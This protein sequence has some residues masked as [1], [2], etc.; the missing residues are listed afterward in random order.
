MNLPAGA[1]VTFA[2]TGTV[3]TNPPPESIVNTATVASTPLVID[4]NLT[5]NS[6]TATTTLLLFRNGFE[7]GPGFR[8]EDLTASAGAKSLTLPAQ[9]VHGK[10]AG[11]SPEFIAGYRIGTSLALLSART[12]GGSTQ[13]S[14][15]HRDVAGTWHAGPWIDVAAER[16][17]ELL[18]R[19]VPTA[20]DALGLQVAVRER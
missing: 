12:Y 2:I 17:V 9:F 7:D 6:A 4:S 15:V 3:P 11:A 20:Q 13:V 1:S 14:V 18:W 16:T 19:S 5:N 8:L 10:A